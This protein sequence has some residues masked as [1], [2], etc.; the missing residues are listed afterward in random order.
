M[1]LFAPYLCFPVDSNGWLWVEKLF[2]AVPAA[3][4]LGL[5]GQGDTLYK[6]SQKE[7]Q[8]EAGLQKGHEAG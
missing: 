1:R 5:M 3:G 4:K 6:K 8:E 7:S 2:S